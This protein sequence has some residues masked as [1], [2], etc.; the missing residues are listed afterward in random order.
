MKAS[1][2]MKAAAEVTQRTCYP[3]ID[4]IGWCTKN[5]DLC[6]R[7]ETL[8]VDATVAK[9]VSINGSSK[10]LEIVKKTQAVDLL[11]LKDNLAALGLR[12]RHCSTHHN[13]ADLWTKSVSYETL[14]TIKNLIGRES[15]HK[16]LF[17]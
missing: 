2:K 10:T 17:S 7:I 12:C 13:V 14:K 4:L 8:Y 6:I 16:E 15:G 11:N 3:I 5:L 9:A 1:N